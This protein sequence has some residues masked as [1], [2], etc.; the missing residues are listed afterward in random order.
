M[1]VIGEQAWQHW[2]I[3]FFIFILQGAWHIHCEWSIENLALSFQNNFQE[4]DWYGR[5]FLVQMFGQQ[6]H[7]P[8]G[9]LFKVSEME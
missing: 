3:K 2:N 7:L 1:T 6:L 9:D 4:A 8:K 5:L